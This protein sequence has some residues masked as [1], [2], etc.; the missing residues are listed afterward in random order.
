MMD[1]TDLPGVLLRAARMSSALSLGSIFSGSVF[2]R[3]VRLPRVVVVRIQFQSG[4]FEKV[5]R[6]VRGEGLD[7]AKFAFDRA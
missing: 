1:P 3:D 4:A 2:A 7:L 6:V 5:G